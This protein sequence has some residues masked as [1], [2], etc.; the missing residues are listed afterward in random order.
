M[1][2]PGFQPE[3]WDVRG[4]LYYQQGWEFCYLTD[5]GGNQSYHTSPGTRR[6][7]HIIRGI[8]VDSDPLVVIV[9]M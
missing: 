8:L 3:H 6:L 2:E 7:S 4:S 5:P 9:P 1:A